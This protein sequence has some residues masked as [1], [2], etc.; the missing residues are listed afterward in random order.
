ML[1]ATG[2]CKSFGTLTAVD[3]LSLSV[4]RGELL[5]LLGP[6]GAG[7]TTTIRMIVGLLQPDGGEVLYDGSAFSDSV[8]GRLGYLPEERGL[9]RKSTVIDTLLY[10]AEL[11]SRRRENAR[12]DALIWLERLGL[13]NRSHT[14]VQELS[15]G[16]Q[17]KVQFVA[18]ILHDPDLVMLDEPLSGFDPLNQELFKD[19]LLELRQKGK[20]VILSTHQMDEAERLCDSL[21]LID[22]G[23]IV[24]EGGLGEIKRRYGTNTLHV[25]FEGDG[26]FLPSLPGVLRAVLHTN[27][28]ELDLVAGTSPRP[29][30]ARMNEVLQ[31][32]SVDLREPSLH[33][34][35]LRTV[36]DGT[37]HESPPRGEASS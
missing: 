10:L 28:A 11:R 2:L 12:R 19:I 15:K 22:R 23:R 34:I 30:I 24:L 37:L 32:R 35:F 14:R 1:V 29:L 13:G 8:R 21:C 18:A 27:A 20:A 4:R 31:L 36:G 26:S 9:Y 16:N 7:K 5:G 3:G 17:Q 25:E 33:A 6:N